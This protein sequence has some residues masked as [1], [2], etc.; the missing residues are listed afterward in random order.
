MDVTREITYIDHLL[1]VI[2]L[3][4]AD[5]TRRH[6]SAPPDTLDCIAHT[7]SSTWTASEHCRR[8]ATSL[9]LMRDRSTLLRAT[10]TPARAATTQAQGHETR[11]NQC[12]DYR[13]VSD[14]TQG[15]LLTGPSP[16]TIQCRCAAD[17]LLETCHYTCPRVSH[18]WT[19]DSEERGK[20][21]V[22]HAAE[23]AI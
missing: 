7:Y 14:L 16:Q 12:I 18:S 8:G 4:H 21:F 11:R 2:D 20:A 15:L 19:S 5:R 17:Y 13:E 10:K 6:R 1:L 9:F 22:E 23:A 3:H